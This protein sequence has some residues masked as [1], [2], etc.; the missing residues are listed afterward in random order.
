MKKLYILLFALVGMIGAN[1]QWV[2]MNA[3]ISST[4]NSVFFIDPSNGYAVGWEI[5]KTTDGGNLWNSQ[6]AADERY[7]VFFTS[8][9]TGYAVGQDFSWHSYGVFKTTNAGTSWDDL[10]FPHSVHSIFFTDSYTGYAGLHPYF[11]LKTTDGGLNWSYLSTPEISADYISSIF[12]IDENNGFVVTSD[13]NVGYILK[14]TNGG[15]DWSIKDT[16]NHEGG[17]KSI[18]FADELNGYAVGGVQEGGSSLFGYLFK[19]TNGG[20]DWIDT[21]FYFYQPGF[22]D[23]YFIDLNTGYIVGQYGLILKTTDAGETWFEQYS[24]TTSTLHSVY[25]P[26]T[27]TGYIVGDSGII[28][29]TT[30]G[31]GG[32]VGINHRTKASNGLKISPNPSVKNISISTQFIIGITKLSIYNVSGEKVIERQLT[33]TETQIDISALPRG[34]YFVRVQD[35]NIIETV[36]MI[37]Q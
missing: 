24:G 23:V 21:N 1:A 35:E 5:L 2:P 29:K 30:N 27:D 34:V 4:L 37:I 14:T 33:N 19:T 20:E 11:L 31:G 16:C 12:F 26:S 25:F 7:D 9:D 13:Y 15:N 6:G 10:D 8:Q 22:A 36:K 32:P 3:G 28:L 18:F 17:L